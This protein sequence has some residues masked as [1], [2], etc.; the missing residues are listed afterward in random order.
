MTIGEVVAELECDGV[1]VDAF[2]RRIYATI[3]RVKANTKGQI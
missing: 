2:I 3:E 1:G